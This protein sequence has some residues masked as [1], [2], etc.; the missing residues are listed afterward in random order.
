MK[1]ALTHW[2]THTLSSIRVYWWQLWRL[3]PA[4]LLN[5]NFL[6]L[7]WRCSFRTWALAARWLWHTWFCSTCLLGDRCRPSS[8]WGSNKR[9]PHNDYSRASTQG[10]VP[11]WDSPLPWGGHRCPVPRPCR[12]LITMWAGLRGSTPPPWTCFDWGESL[13]G[14]LKS[15]SFIKITV[16]LSWSKRGEI[17]HIDL[18]FVE[19][20]PLL[21]PSPLSLKKDIGL[22]MLI[23]LWWEDHNKLCIIDYLLKLLKFQHN[24][25]AEKSNIQILN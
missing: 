9:L 8:L 10:R 11:L 20:S 22:A 13:H 15:D 2:L 21:L 1:I 16:L 14:S 12:G 4:L 7:P 3:E 25:E 19:R 23:L 18:F 17:F 24:A 5:A 6:P